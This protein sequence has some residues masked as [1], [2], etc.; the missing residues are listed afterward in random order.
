MFFEFFV[1]VMLIVLFKGHYVLF[2]KI[3]NLKV[4]QYEYIEDRWK[5]LDKHLMS[6]LEI[7]KMDWRAT[8]TRV[9][10]IVASIK[11]RLPDAKSDEEKLP[12]AKSDKDRKSIFQT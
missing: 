3:K 6:M 11:K 12:D 7:Q 1:C 8:F 4:N 9:E 10:A 2:T 5:H